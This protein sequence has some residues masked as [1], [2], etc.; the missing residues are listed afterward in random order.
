MFLNTSHVVYEYIS[1]YSPASVHCELVSQLFIKEFCSGPLVLEETNISE[2]ILLRMLVDMQNV[3]RCQIEY[4]LVLG[5]WPTGSLQQGIRN[6]NS[7][8][9]AYMLQLASTFH[10]VFLC[11]FTRHYLRNNSIS[12]SSHPYPS[13]FS[14]GLQRDVL[15]DLGMRAYYHL[16]ELAEEEENT[17]KLATLPCSNQTEK[18][19]V[20]GILQK[21]QYARAGEARVGCEKM[22]P[23]GFAVFIAFCKLP[24]GGTHSMRFFASSSDSTIHTA[25][26]IASNGAVAVIRRICFVG[27]RDWSVEGIAMNPNHGT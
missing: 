21:G 4:R 25:K 2:E 27:D 9:S 14:F 17:I 11:V 26:Q 12:F 16:Q 15:L 6:L 7:M 19:L 23:L 3:R 8:K 20:H 5:P 18:F 13:I 1:Y 24:W 22:M 10:Q